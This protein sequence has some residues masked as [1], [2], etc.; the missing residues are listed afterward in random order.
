MHDLTL[1]Y[2][3]ALTLNLEPAFSNVVVI[4]FSYANVDG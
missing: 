4:T 3:S 1:F 2:H